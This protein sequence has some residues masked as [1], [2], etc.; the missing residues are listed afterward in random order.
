MKLHL[1]CGY[2]HLEGWVNVDQDPK[3]NP[4]E[5]FDLTKPDWPIDDNSV[6]EVL[7]EHVLEHIEGTEGYATLWKEIHRVCKKGA[8]IKIEVPHWKHDTFIHDPTHVRAVTPIGL[9]MMDQERNESDRV[10]NGRET[11][12]GFIWGIDFQMLTVAYGQDQLNGEPITCNYQL[13]A[14]KPCRY[15]A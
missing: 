11:K 6:E 2:K 7:M 1:G 4:D 5:V 15:K 13:K 10:N 14:I 9:A 3:C 12:L 8:V